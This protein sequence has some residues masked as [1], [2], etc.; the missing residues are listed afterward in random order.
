MAQSQ[1]VV[2]PLHVGDRWEY[3][4]LGPSPWTSVIERDT[5]MPNGRHYAVRSGDYHYEFGL[6]FERQ[7][8]NSVFRFDTLKNGE[9]LWYNFDLSAGDTVG[10]YARGS[11]TMD[12]VLVEARVDTIFGA[13]RR[14]WL[15]MIDNYRA[16]ADDE[17]YV[18]ITDSLGLT[19][20]GEAFAG[21]ELRGAVIGGVR[22]GT[23]SA[24]GPAPAVVP[25]GFQLGV[26]Y[27]NPF[28]PTTTITYT[29]PS[30]SL[31]TLK[32]FNL[33]GQ[34]VASIVDEIEGP[35]SRAVAF[36][37]GGLPSGMYFYRLQA[38]GCSDVKKLLL[39]K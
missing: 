17:Q 21:A 19:D 7:Q 36:N 38:G 13:A 2:Y 31:V 27:P 6:V 16:W 33:L 4:Y 28:N 34:E 11:D 26:N 12:I 22:Y 14:T 24:V 15:F 20:Y 1:A 30:R 25:L 3:T 29:V 37:A 18:V 39:M 9:Q 35:G 10:S 32:V 5:L 8:E 23:V